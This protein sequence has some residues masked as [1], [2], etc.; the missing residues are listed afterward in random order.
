MKSES[1]LVSSSTGAVHVVIQT[2]GDN[3]LL[4]GVLQK[5][6]KK[7]ISDLTLLTIEQIFFEIEHVHP[8]VNLYDEINTVRDTFR[9]KEED[10][11]V[12]IRPSTKRHNQ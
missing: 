8:D 10:I 2:A 9:M 4:G 3:S 1:H 6:L 7:G 11:R 5:L 12:H